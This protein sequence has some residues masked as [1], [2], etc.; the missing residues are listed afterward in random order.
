MPPKGNEQLQRDVEAIGRS[1]RLPRSRRGCRPSAGATDAAVSSLRAAE[2]RRATGS[3]AENVVVIPTAAAGVPADPT[4]PG[5]PGP[6]FPARAVNGGAEIE[7]AASSNGRFVVVG[8]NGGWANSQ[9]AGRT[10]S[11][12]TGVNCPAGFTSCNGDPS[13][14]VGRSGNF[15]AAIIG[16]PTGHQPSG[17]GRHCLERGPAFHRQRPDL[18]VR[19]QL[20]RLQQLRRGLVLPRPGAHHGRPRD[21]RR[22]RR[23]SRSI[24]PGATSMRR[25]RTRRSSARRTAARTGRPRSTSEPASSRG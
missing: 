10:W 6:G 16:W 2:E 4:G 3:L 17:S 8:T 13:V 9:D 12:T 18:H 22:G 14:A 7:V 1:V 15:Y 21:R 25:T 24:R 23:G 20:R 5:L 11:A 19:Q